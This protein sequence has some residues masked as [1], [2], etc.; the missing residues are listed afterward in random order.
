MP[1]RLMPKSQAEIKPPFQQYP[2]FNYF[3]PKKYHVNKYMILS[4]NSIRLYS[5]VCDYAIYTLNYYEMHFFEGAILKSTY[6]LKC[7]F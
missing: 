6:V 4:F 2:F 7:I 1:K 5:D 3:N